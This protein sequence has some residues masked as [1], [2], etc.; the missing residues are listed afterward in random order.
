MQHVREKVYTMEQ[1]HMTLKQKY[2]A[3]LALF[4]LS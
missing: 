1:T 3:L 2:V 4:A